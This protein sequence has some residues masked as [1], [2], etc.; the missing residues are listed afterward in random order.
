MQAKTN[1]FYDFGAFRLDPVERVLLSA[2]KR[3]SLTP[4]AFETL[5]VLIENAGHI[6]EKD[7]LLKRVWPN[8][9]VEE[10]TLARNISTLRKALGDGPEGQ[11]YIETVPRRGYCFAALVQQVPYDEPGDSA[12]DAVRQ[13]ITT[14]AEPRASWP[15]RWLLATGL[16]AVLFGGAYVFWQRSHSAPAQ[17]VMLVVLPFENLSGDPAQDYLGDGL[18]EE[19]IT[20]LGQLRPDGLGVIARTT[21]MTYQG[22]HK[23]VAEIGRELHVDYVIEGSV[24]RAGTRVRVSAQLISVPDQT[25]LWAENYERDI[26]DLLSVESEVAGQIADQVEIK[27][28][29]AARQRLASARPVNPEENELYL[30]GRYFWNK[31]TMDST[32]KARDYFA[33][34]I[35]LDASDA[36]SYAALAE[37]YSG[38][39]WADLRQYAAPAVAKAIELDDTLPEAHTSNAILKMYAYDWAGAEQEFYRAL[40][41]DPNSANALVWHS[42][43]LETEGRVDEGIAEAHRALSLD[44]LSAV[45]NQAWGTTLF[46]ARRYDEAAEALRKTIELD[47]TFV[48]AH[49]R[50][51]RVYEQQGRFAESEA[52]FLKT[53]PPVSLQQTANLRLAHMYAISGRRGEAVSL[54]PAGMPSPQFDIAMV[55][56]GLGEKARAREMLEQ[57]VELH[58][59]NVIYLKV[60]P[61]LD[62][63]RNDPQFLALLHKAGLQ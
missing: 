45:A 33:R 15:P 62:A 53:N 58:D 41:L 59:V 56:L 35:A 52:E 31:R 6:L 21:A 28:T 24:R 8:T 25:H 27:L 10:G 9:F 48:W 50:L 49:L 40:R 38:S 14:R 11:T 51:A 29:P 2:G 34:A 5:L 57:I 36:R 22:T 37:T 13:Q 54:L 4:K 30:K 19:M 42:V 32:S 18:T 60:D 43:L 46:F 44:P 16:L 1:C 39:N 17:P 20:Q 61:A 12:G 63:L 47:P 3:V 23:S 7:D 26:R 55:Y